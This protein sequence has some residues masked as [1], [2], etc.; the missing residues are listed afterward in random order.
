M[1]HPQ[2][3]HSQVS[4]FS[5]TKSMNHPNCGSC[6]RFDCHKTTQTKVVQNR[7]QPHSFGCRPIRIL[8]CSRPKLPQCW[9]K[10]SRIGHHRGLVASNKVCVT[11]HSILLSSGVQ[12]YLQAI[13]VFDCVSCNSLEGNKV[14]VEE[15][16]EFHRSRSTSA[17]RT[18]LASSG[19]IPTKE[20]PRPHLETYILVHGDEF[21]IVGRQEGVNMC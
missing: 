21:F 8:R 20:V 3:S 6:V 7:L 18:R 11:E 17:N 5:Q 13:R 9:T 10:F 14:S 1:L 12:G 16:H 2:V 15:V 4:D 19:L